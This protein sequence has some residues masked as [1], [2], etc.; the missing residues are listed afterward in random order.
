DEAHAERAV[1]KLVGVVGSGAGLLDRADDPVLEL[2]NTLLFALVAERRIDQ[3]DPGRHARAVIEDLIAVLGVPRRALTSCVGPRTEQPLQ[4]AH[5]RQ[6]LPRAGRPAP[7][8]AWSLANGATCS[9]WSRGARRHRSGRMGA[10]RA[11]RH[12]Q[13]PLVRPRAAAALRPGHSSHSS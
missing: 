8:T 12:A 3:S 11:A 1:D 13:T 2:E 7:V 10:L 6:R 4:E 5:V 9:Q